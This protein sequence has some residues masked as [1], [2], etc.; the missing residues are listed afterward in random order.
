[1]M[2]KESNNLF[3]WVGWE[4]GM[5]GVRGDGGSEGGWVAGW[6]IYCVV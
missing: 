6:N 1:M 5:G 4:G 3:T 2:Q